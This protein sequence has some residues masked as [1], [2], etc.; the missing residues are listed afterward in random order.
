MDNHQD[1]IY[2]RRDISP[3]KARVTFFMSLAVPA[4]I[5]PSFHFMISNQAFSQTLK[6][7]K[8]YF[9]SSCNI[10]YFGIAHFSQHLYSFTAI[11]FRCAS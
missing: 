4:F 11:A 9:A 2:L 5:L 6:S 7:T 1:V 3:V 8:I 10:L